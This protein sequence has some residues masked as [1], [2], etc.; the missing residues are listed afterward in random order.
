MLSG[1]DGPYDLVFYDAAV[2]TSAHLDAFSRLLAPLGTLLTSNLF[3]G[4][5]EPDHPRLADGGVYRDRLFGGGWSTAFVG[6]TAVDVV[7]AVPAVDVGGVVPSPEVHLDAGGGPVL[8]EDGVVAPTGADG[9]SAAASCL[10]RRRPTQ[11]E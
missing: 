3:L 1:L 2:P 10:V 6:T 4:L 11:E 7:D 9:G 8:C 5:Y